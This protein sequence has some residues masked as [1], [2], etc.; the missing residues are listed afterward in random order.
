M[1][2]KGKDSKGA[3]EAD[4]AQLEKWVSGYYPPGWKTADIKERSEPVFPNQMLQY[5]NRKEHCLISGFQLLGLVLAV[6]Q[7]QISPEQAQGHLLKAIG[8]CSALPEIS[9]CLRL[10][11]QMD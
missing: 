10:L 2:V 1:E 4:A 7:K 8:V 9:D 11:G 6:Q 3:A 5:A